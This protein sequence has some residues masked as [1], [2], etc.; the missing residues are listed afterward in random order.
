MNDLFTVISL[1]IAISGATYAAIVALRTYLWERIKEPMDSVPTYIEPLLE[2]KNDTVK[3]RATRWKRR[4]DCF[5]CVW[6]W[7][8]ILPI[9]AFA[10]ISYGQAIHAVAAY[11]NMSSPP[12]VYKTVA[13][14]TTRDACQK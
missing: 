14:A 2:S 10:F 5:Q 3:G 9:A 12:T 6:R 13:P 7:A 8:F 4:L 1:V 11:W